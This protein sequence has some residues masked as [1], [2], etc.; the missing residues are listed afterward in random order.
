MVTMRTNFPPARQGLIRW[1]VRKKQIV[2]CKGAKDTRRPDQ[3]EQSGT[4]GKTRMTG[5]TAETTQG[6]LSTPLVKRGNA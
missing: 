1:F 3:F 2:S 5:E 4:F 6:E